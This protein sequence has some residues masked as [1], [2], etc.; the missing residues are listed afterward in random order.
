LALPVFCSTVFSGLFPGALCS[1]FFYFF[2]P[3]TSLTVLFFV[4]HPL[5]SYLSLSLFSPSIGLLFWWHFLVFSCFSGWIA[6]FFSK[7]FFFRDL[8]LS[9]LPRTS[10]DPTFA[11]LPYFGIQPFSP[12]CHQS[13]FVSPPS[14][15]H[16]P[17][18]SLR[19]SSI[20]SRQRLS[21]FF[22]FSPLSLSIRRLLTLLHYP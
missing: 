20:V 14:S 8:F 9:Q 10:L 15:A 4:P 16:F 17:S 1:S 2:P 19:I 6:L 5:W 18:W 3:P 13:F 12:F 22:H 7:L 21:L 11:P